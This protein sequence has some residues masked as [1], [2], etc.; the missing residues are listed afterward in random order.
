MEG[1]LAYYHLTI[2]LDG[3]DGAPPTMNITTRTSDDD[4]DHS[5][6]ELAKGYTR[7]KW[8]GVILDVSMS[9]TDIL[10]PA[11]G[12]LRMFICGLSSFAGNLATDVGGEIQ[13]MFASR[14]AMATLAVVGNEPVLLYN[15]RGDDKIPPLFCLDK[16]SSPYAK[17]TPPP[18]N[19][20]E[21]SSIVSRYEAT[22][23]AK[24]EEEAKDEEDEVKEDEE[25]EVKEDEEEGREETKD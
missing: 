6:Y 21:I 12:G 14:A 23:T 16:A 11:E 9:D 25:D 8:V 5:S 20:W 22:T 4:L 7:A 17:L 24:I 2:K 13:V 18:G 10:P 19:D 3:E 1:K 15:R